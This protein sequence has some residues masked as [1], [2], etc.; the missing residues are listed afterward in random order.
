MFD[1]LKLQTVTYRNSDFFETY[2]KKILDKKIV[3]IMRKNQ[4][5]G[6]QFDDLKTKTLYILTI[7]IF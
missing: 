3:K 1:F 7:K 6:E 5:F 2:Y 4:H